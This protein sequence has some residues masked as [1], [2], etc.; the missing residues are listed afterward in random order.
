M[1]ATPSERQFVGRWTSH[2]LDD[3]DE[4]LFPSISD[5]SVNSDESIDVENERTDDLAREEDEN[6]VSMIQILLMRL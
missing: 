3:N 5:D 1:E 4:D 6:I 2:A